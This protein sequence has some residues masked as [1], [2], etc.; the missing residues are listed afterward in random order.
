MAVPLNMTTRLARVHCHDEGDGWGSAEPYLWAVFFKIDGDN[1]AVQ[2]GS[3]LIG[4]PVIV[5]TN[6]SHG[7]LGDTDV[8]AGDD[9]TIPE[10]IGAWSTQLKP[11]PI[12]DPVVRALLRQDN[13]PG[14]AGVV[15]TLMEEDGWPHS[16]ANDGYSAFVNAVHLAVVKV[17]ADFQRATSAPTEEEIKERIDQVKGTAASTV[18]TQVKGSMNAWELLWFGTFGDN[19]DT[20]GSEA[21][22]VDSDKLR[23]TPSIDFQR[24]W[25]GEESGDGDWELHGWFSGVA[26]LPPG[27]CNLDGLF[28]ATPASEELKGGSFDAMRGFRDE[29]FR[30][31]AG[32]DAWWTEA[33]D[34]MPEL[35]HLVHEDREVGEALQAL[36]TEAPRV[37][38]DPSSPVR[39]QDVDNLR[40]ILRRLG[41]VSPRHRRAFAAQGLRVL[42]E[43]DGVPWSEALDFVAVAKPRGRKLRERAR[44]HG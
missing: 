14:I 8:D 2:S 25:R 33:Q 43:I 41:E 15:M 21:F 36:L 16:L 42:P 27:D 24:R 7:N 22:V 35:V 4:S 10:S 29:E 39:S 23:A 44:R 20:I 9:V 40:L 11:I 37:L 18:K 19:D 1:F 12:H 5:S 30:S 26:T 6:G 3:G 38:G 31:Y 34:A 28:A 17:A 32:L 13:L